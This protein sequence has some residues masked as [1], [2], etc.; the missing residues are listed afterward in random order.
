MTTQT[1]KQNAKTIQFWDDYYASLQLLQ[2]QQRTFT[3][4]LSGDESEGDPNTQ[5]GTTCTSNKDPHNLMTATTTGSSHE[6]ESEES[7]LS[8]AKKPSC[9][10]INERGKNVFGDKTTRSLS[11]D[12]NRSISSAANKEWIVQ[13]NAALF[14]VLRSHFPQDDDDEY[15]A[16]ACNNAETCAVQ[17]HLLEIGCGVSTFAREL[18]LFLNEDLR[19]RLAEAQYSV[20]ATD[21]SQVCIDQM[22]ARDKS[23]IQD[24]IT[25]SRELFG[26]QV[27]DILL[28]ETSHQS[29]PSLSSTSTTSNNNQQQ[30]CKYTY[31]DVI[32]DKG[33][34]DTFLFRSE[35]ALRQTLVQRCLDNVHRLL[36]FQGRY[37]ILSPRSKIKFA[38]DYNGFKEV[39]RASIGQQENIIVADLDRRRSSSSSSNGKQQAAV[40]G[41]N[42][43]SKSAPPPPPVYLYVC[44]KDDTYIPGKDE[45]FRNMQGNSDTHS[46]LADADYD[47]SSTIPPCPKC[48]MLFL[49]EFVGGGIESK[50]FQSQGIKVWHRRWKGHKMHCKG[51]GGANGSLK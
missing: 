40:L 29:S 18:Y 37:L 2:S 30:Q 49:D 35:H 25:D 47:S 19:L 7:A 41:S 10:I 36:S 15:T 24:T 44:I 20:T 6:E 21:V 38:R 3:G 45:P 51:D 28:E 31:Y 9:S 32:L 16:D 43:K 23:V 12:A 8:S 1:Q 17:Q 26:Y 48:G 27:L 33:C 22:N 46:V 11:S 14:E 5:E 34:L 50:S 39:Q 42:T 13:P 4:T